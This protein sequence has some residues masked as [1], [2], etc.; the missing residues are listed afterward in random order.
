[1]LD[2]DDRHDVLEADDDVGRLEQVVDQVHGVLALVGQVGEELAA[3]A[4]ENVAGG[5]HLQKYV[6]IEA[7]VYHESLKQ[8]L[9]RVN[10]HILLR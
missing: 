5:L 8:Q 2:D 6:Q 9:R 1:M 10:V 3:C 4:G 7:L